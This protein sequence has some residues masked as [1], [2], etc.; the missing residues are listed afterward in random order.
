MCVS[1]LKGTF[2]GKKVDGSENTPNEQAREMVGRLNKKEGQVDGGEREEAEDRR[3]T[4]NPGKGI[5]V[6]NVGG[7]F[8]GRDDPDRCCWYRVAFF[9]NC[10]ARRRTG[11]D[12]DRT[13]QDK[14]HTNIFLRRAANKGALESTPGFRKLL[15]A[16]CGTHQ[17]S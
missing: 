10:C 17:A 1:E 15:G 8:R 11:S 16:T 3:S 2:F 9:F 13:G 6:N 4:L 14:G 7:Y 5:L 12:Q